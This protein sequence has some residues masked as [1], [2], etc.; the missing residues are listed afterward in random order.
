MAMRLKQLR[1]SKGFSQEGMAKS[2]GMTQKSWDRWESHPPESFTH[3]RR[4]AERYKVSADYLLG[5]VDDPFANQDLSTDEQTTLAALRALRG[6]DKLVARTL[7][8]VLA[9]EEPEERRFTLDVI[10]RILRPAQPHIIGEDPG[11]DVDMA[12]SD[13]PD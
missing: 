5:I 12:T 11:D 7:L 9:K 1:D 4:I 8:A 10:A 6:K 13:Q 2:V 3:L